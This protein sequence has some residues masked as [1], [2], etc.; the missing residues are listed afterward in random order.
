MA[1]AHYIHSRNT[2]N[3]TMMIC[4]VWIISIVVSLAPLLGWKDDSWSE[5][6]QA[7]ECMVSTGILYIVYPNY[8]LCKLLT[9]DQGNLVGS[10]MVL[11]NFW[12][13]PWYL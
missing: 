8:E 3:I 5:R 1:Q 12:I 2:R 6:V 11:I 7:G 13:P 9:Y 4:L 10:L